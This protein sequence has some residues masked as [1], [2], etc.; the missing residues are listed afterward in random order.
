MAQRTTFAIQPNENLMTKKK[1]FIIVVSFFI[2]WGIG[3]GIFSLDNNRSLKRLC[4][5]CSGSYESVDFRGEQKDVQVTDRQQIRI[6]LDELANAPDALAPGRGSAYGNIVYVH[7]PGCKMVYWIT[8]DQRTK[9]QY[10]LGE[11]RYDHEL[12]Q[13]RQLESVTLHEWLEKNGLE[14]ASQQV[15]NKNQ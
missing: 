7:I 9:E 12:W 1:K 13:V 4:Q 8:R 14:S 11:L 6:L 2:I 3:F 10:D 15:G 5:V